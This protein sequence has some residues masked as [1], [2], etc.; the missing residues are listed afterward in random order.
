MNTPN[1]SLALALATARW[2]NSETARRINARAEQEGHRSVAVDR[3]RVG[4]WIRHGE[5]PRP[6]VPELL[7]A[8]LTEHLG[9]PYH[10]QS[11]G[12]APLRSVRVP[13]EEAGYQ[14]LKANAAAANMPVE[15]YARALIHSA[16]TATGR[17]RS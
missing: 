3:S 12:I 17:S 1:Y 4:R 7:A 6:P 8:L 15:N 10:P 5:K 13:L 9:Q 16:L 11:L 2:T 14:A